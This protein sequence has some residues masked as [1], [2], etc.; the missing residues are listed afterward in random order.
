[1]KPWIYAAPGVKGLNCWQCCPASCVSGHVFHW[2]IEISN[3]RRSLSAIPRINN[4]NITK[5]AEY[6]LGVNR[7]LAHRLRSWP[8]IRPTLGQSLVLVNCEQCHARI[9][10][11]WLSVPA[12][13][14]SIN[15]T[16]L[17]ATTVLNAVDKCVKR[18][19]AWM[20]FLR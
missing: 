3:R 18:H 15:V 6:R 8:N 10:F 2:T 4:I 12:G 9:V 13:I 16:W 19:K 17:R 20:V 1:M 7:M 5:D 11:F 14:G